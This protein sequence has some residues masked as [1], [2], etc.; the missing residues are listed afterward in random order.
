ME[1]IPPISQ[2]LQEGPFETVKVLVYGKDSMNIS[3]YRDLHCVAVEFAWKPECHQ[4]AV[5]ETGMC[6][7]REGRPWYFC[8]HSSS[9]QLARPKAQRCQDASGRWTVLPIWTEGARAGAL[10]AALANLNSSWH[11]SRRVPQ[12]HLDLCWRQRE[13]TMLALEEFKI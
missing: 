11:P 3:Y 5:T 1:I 13:S 12:C 8:F 2:D 4:R 7:G 6:W 10:E 9:A